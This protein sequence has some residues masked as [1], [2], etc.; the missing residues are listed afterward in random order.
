[1]TYLETQVWYMLRTETL[2]RWTGPAPVLAAHDLLGP[3]QVVAGVAHVRD[4]GSRRVVA[5]FGRVRRTVL[6]N[7]W[8]SAYNTYKL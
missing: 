1:M 7:S 5:Q 8:M 3:V 6:R 4:D 2:R